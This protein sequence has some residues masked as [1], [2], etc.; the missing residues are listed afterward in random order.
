MR[1]RFANMNM[2]DN[3]FGQCDSNDEN[4]QEFDEA[5]G[6]GEEVANEEVHNVL[7]V[8]AFAVMQVVS[9][10]SKTQRFEMEE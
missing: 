9:Q 1:Q 5:P 4:S 3:W 2:C 7:L 8:L 10:N 6:E